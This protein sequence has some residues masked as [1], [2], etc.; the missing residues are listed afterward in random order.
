[1]RK[2]ALLDIVAGIALGSEFGKNAQNRMAHVFLEKG[3][4]CVFYRG[5][6]FCK[7]RH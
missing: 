7:W 5:L 3:E 4:A 2:T 1:M 6:A